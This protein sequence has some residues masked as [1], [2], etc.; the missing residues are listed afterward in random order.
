LPLP[1]N[2]NENYNLKDVLFV[3]AGA[4]LIVGFLWFITL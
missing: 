2:D 1:S 3:L 4:L